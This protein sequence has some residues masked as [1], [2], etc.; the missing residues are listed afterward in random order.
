M[1][2]RL[3]P[4]ANG[5][6][7]YQMYWLPPQHLKSSS[8][9]KGF[10]AYL[11]QRNPSERIIVGAYGKDFAGDFS[12]GIHRILEDTNF[13]NFSG[14]QRAYNWETSARGFLKAFGMQSGITGTPADKIFIDDP[15]KGYRD[16]FS[17]A[18]R[19]STY[20]A[21]VYDI[22]TRQQKNTSHIIIQ[23]RWHCDDLSGRLLERDGR[24]EDGGKWEVICL[25]ALAEENDPLGRE[26]GEPLCPELHSLEELLELKKNEPSMFQALYQQSP[27]LNDGNLI[28]I[29]K[30]NYYNQEIVKEFDYTIMSVDG[31]WKEKEA[32]DYSV[33]TIWGVIGTNY[34]LRD[35]WR[36]KVKYPVFKTIIKSI[37]DKYEA[38]FV[39]VEDAASGIPLIQELGHL[40]PMHPCKPE[41][42]KTVRVHMISDIINTG[43]VYLPE[44]H[45]LMYDFIQEMSSFPKGKHDD[46]VDTVTQALRYL[47]SISP[48]PISFF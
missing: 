38:M 33:C 45:N 31:A 17:I 8:V 3:Q 14:K 6:K 10:P 22:C 41:G 42:D 47:S 48:N 16:A 15:V 4:I 18:V 19:D 44:N 5:E 11:Y 43:R 24:I 46:I 7:R 28:D 26:I 20:N 40:I 39:L 23:T 12:S 37:F 32:N 9:T 27:V 13:K 36:D 25:P 29:S 30:F 34:Y 21:Y 35:M 1:T 2:N